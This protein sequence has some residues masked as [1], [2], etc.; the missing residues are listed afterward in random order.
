VKLRGKEIYIIAGVVGVVLIAAWFFLFFNPVRS[1]LASLDKQI[2][3]ANTT[4]NTKKMELTSYQ[5]LKSTAPQSKVD[6]VRLGKMMPS[7]SNVPTAIVELTQTA[8]LSGLTFLGITPSVASAG[9]PFGMQSITLKLQGT[10]FDLED[11]LYRLESY[12]QFRNDDFLVTGRLLQPVNL[13]LGPANDVSLPSDT[14]NISLVV[15]A[16]LWPV[17]AGMPTMTMTGGTS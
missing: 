10:Y 15:N 13:Q 1:K 5:Q 14:L 3:T 4:L 17:S 9:S 8:K 2:A 11:Y 16:Y 6:L 7:Q 12:V